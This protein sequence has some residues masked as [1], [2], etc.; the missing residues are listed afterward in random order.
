MSAKLRPVDV[1]MPVM[2]CAESVYG[3]PSV[4]CA[5]DNL[6]VVKEQCPRNRT[7]RTQKGHTP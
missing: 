2:K 7:T 3:L 5:G 1:D 4:H 6:Q